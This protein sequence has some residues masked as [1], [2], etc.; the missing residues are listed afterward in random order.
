MFKHPK[1]VIGSRMKIYTPMGK[2]KNRKQP[3][4]TMTQQEHY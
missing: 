2:V 3:T 1:K 4:T